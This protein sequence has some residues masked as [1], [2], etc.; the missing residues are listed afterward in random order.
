[1]TKANYRSWNLLLVTGKAIYNILVNWY[2]LEAYFRCI[3]QML[4]PPV[5]IKP[6]KF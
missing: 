3:Y 4:M 6:A 2:E 5:V 1:M